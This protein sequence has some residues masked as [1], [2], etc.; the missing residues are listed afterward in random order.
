MSSESG[1]LV[2]GMLILVAVAV[3]GVSLEQLL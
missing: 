1:F 3:A 2:V